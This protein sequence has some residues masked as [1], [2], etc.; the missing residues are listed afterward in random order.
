MLLNVS[1]TLTLGRY[2]RSSDKQLKLGIIYMTFV[3]WNLIC[4]YRAGFLTT[5]AKELSKY[6]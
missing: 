5:A 4:L 1:Y 6:R 3:T 2:N